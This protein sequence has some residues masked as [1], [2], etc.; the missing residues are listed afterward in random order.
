MQIRRIIHAAKPSSISAFRQS[1]AVRQ[2]IANQTISPY[3]PDNA[4]TRSHTI[5]LLSRLALDAFVALARVL[6]AWPKW[7]KVFESFVKRAIG[8][9]EQ[10]N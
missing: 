7:N 5:L 8:R 6:E 10:R 2:K 9:A 3:N 4:V 1:T